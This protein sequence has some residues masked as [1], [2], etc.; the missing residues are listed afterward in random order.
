MCVCVMVCVC[1]CVCVCVCVC[2]WERERERE[3]SIDNLFQVTMN[4]ICKCFANGLGCMSKFMVTCGRLTPSLEN[5][6]CTCRPAKEGIDFQPFTIENVGS[7]GLGFYSRPDKKEQQ[8]FIS[9]FHSW[10]TSRRP[11]PAVGQPLATVGRD[12][13]SALQFLNFF[14]MVY[15][16]INYKLYSYIMCICNFFLS[17]VIM[18]SV[19][20]YNSTFISSF[21]YWWFY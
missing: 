11:G 7:F 14:S 9:R 4:L 13:P 1:D 21:V 8:I 15:S 5:S 2:V 19:F 12:D 18:Y 20:D 3:K 17:L 10:G 16:R 6:L